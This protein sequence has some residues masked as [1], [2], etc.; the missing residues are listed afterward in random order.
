MC[1]PI[2]D[3]KSAFSALLGTGENAFSFYGETQSIKCIE[4]MGCYGG[5]SGLRHFI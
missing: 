2:Y 5:A 4:G 3:L 1:N